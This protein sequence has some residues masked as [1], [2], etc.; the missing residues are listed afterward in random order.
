MRAYTARAPANALASA[1]AS[2][3][4]ATNASA[5]R[6]TNRS[7]RSALR[8]TTRTFSPFASSASAATE[9]VFPVAPIITYM[10]LSLILDSTRP[11]RGAYPLRHGNLHAGLARELDGFGIAGVG[12]SGNTDAGIVGEHALDARG[13]FFG[14]VGDRDLSGVLRVPDAH[15]AA[16]VNRNPRCAAGGIEQGVEQRPIGNGVRAVAHF[17]GFAEGR[18]HRAAIEMVAANHDRRFQFAARDQVVQ[19]QSESVALAVTQ[20]AD[21]RGQSLEAHA[22]LRQADPPAKDFVVRKQLQ[23]Q[24][25]GAVYIRRL[26]GER[27]PAERSAAFAE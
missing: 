4:S 6:F 25:I 24:L 15:A 27:G 22:F 1:A 16:I 2:F 12:V 21:A 26:A 10:A 9:P 7:R 17:F 18:S 14:A 19:R 11:P 3:A 5:P 23:N 13:H 8:P 20:P